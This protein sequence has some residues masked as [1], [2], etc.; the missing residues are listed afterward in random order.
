MLIRFLK[1]YQVFMQAYMGADGRGLIIRKRR[2]IAFKKVKLES[3]PKD[4]YDE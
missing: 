3:L 4:I 1:K 2:M